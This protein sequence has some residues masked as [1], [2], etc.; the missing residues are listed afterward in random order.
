[1]PRV[2]RPI[3]SEGG[4]LLAYRLHLGRLHRVAT[5]I[6]GGVDGYFSSH[7]G[8]DLPPHDIVATI[9]DIGTGADVVVGLPGARGEAQADR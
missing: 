2:N 1:M 8:P 5:G 4:P 9:G 7:P 6:V 3:C